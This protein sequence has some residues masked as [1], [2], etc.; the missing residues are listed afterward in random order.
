[1]LRLNQ[2]LK[3]RKEKG[4]KIHEKGKRDIFLGISVTPVIQRDVEDPRFR[5]HETQRPL[6]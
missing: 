3:K 1:M 4:E 6:A 2:K 5:R